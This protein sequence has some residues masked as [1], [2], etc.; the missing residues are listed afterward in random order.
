MVGGDLHWIWKPYGIYQEVD[1]VRRIFSDQADAF[2]D[3][4]V[5]GTDIRRQGIART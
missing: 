1:Y 5:C 2:L 3:L 4:G